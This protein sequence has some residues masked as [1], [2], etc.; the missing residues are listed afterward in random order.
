MSIN[1]YRLAVFKNL[2]A[3]VAEEMGVVLGR[4]AYSVN[5]KERRDY[6]CAVFDGRGRMIAQAAHIPVHLGSM[7][8]SVEAA[9]RKFSF[10]PDDVIV[11]N[12]PYQGGTHLPDVTF[13]RPV[14]AGNRLEFFTACRAHYSDIGG[15]APG[16]MPVSTDLYQEGFILPPL[17]LTAEVRA[18]LLANVRNPREV[19]GD[20]AAQEAC[21][22]TGAKRLL[23][24]LARYG[25]ELRRYADAL[26]AY[27]RRRMVSAIRKIPAETMRRRA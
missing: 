16:S 13:V 14:F 4:S 7:P 1:T 18:L 19:E 26:Q 9:I 6:S 15:M 2:L 22:A 11:L 23:D 5:I 27:A 24:L 10:K 3:G 21:C 12:D 20:M 25:R 17:R 8:L